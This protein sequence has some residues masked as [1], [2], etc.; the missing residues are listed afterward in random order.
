M[1]RTA[2]SANIELGVCQSEPEKGELVTE[3]TTVGVDLAKNAIVGATAE[4]VLLRARLADCN[5]RFRSWL[6][7]VSAHLHAG[8]YCFP[9]ALVGLLALLVSSSRKMPHAGSRR[10]T[11]ASVP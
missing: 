5:L 1:H 9:P 8:D 7:A 4:C 2:S 11:A 3:I 10:P 6:L